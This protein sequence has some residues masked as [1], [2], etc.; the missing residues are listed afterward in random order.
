MNINDLGFAL[1]S[2][3]LLLS[4]W[5]V[6]YSII[7]AKKVSTLKRNELISLWVHLDR[8]RTLIYQLGTIT[9]EKG[10]IDD[11]NLNIKQIQ[12][13]PLIY[14]GLCDEYIRVA[15]MIAQR[16]PKLNREIIDKW[17]SDNKI[18]SN[19]QKQ[20]FINMIPEE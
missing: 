13:I 6:Y 20:Q 17:E 3:G 18:K 4:I 2:I 14:K 16:T 5:A 12:H 11:P 8:V 15:E 10:I 9:N 1:T 19:W 7:Q